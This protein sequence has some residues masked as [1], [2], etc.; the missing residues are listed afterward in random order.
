MTFCVRHKRNALHV[1]NRRTSDVEKAARA[2]KAGRWRE[3]AFGPID[4]RTRAVDRQRIA[5]QKAKDWGLGQ[6]V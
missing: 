2:V 3:E 1:S 6:L 4:D 5:E